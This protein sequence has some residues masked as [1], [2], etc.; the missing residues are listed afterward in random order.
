MAIKKTVTQ[1]TLILF[2]TITLLYL[3]NITLAQCFDWLCWESNEELF[4]QSELKFIKDM[5]NGNHAPQKES[6]ENDCPYHISSIAYWFAVIESWV[7]KWK[8]AQDT[9]NWYSVKKWS[10]KYRYNRK[11][12]Y[13]YLPASKYLIYENV[14]QSTLDFMYLIKYWYNCKL[15]RPNVYRYKMWAY[16]D[17]EN[18]ARYYRNLISSIENFEKKY[19][20]NWQKITDYQKASSDLYKSDIIENIF[21]W[22]TEILNTAS[23]LTNNSKIQIQK[24]VS[25][26][27]DTKN[28]DK[29]EKLHASANTPNN[30]PKQSEKSTNKNNKIQTSK[31]KINF[32][33][34]KN[35]TPI[36]NSS[37]N[38]SSNLLINQVNWINNPLNKFE[39]YSINK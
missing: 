38:I 19:F 20:W 24:I 35:Y 13:G 26:L 25:K 15:S 31:T 36:N 3:F 16:V 27:Q 28:I 7:W 10:G 37:I 33:S 30:N 14:M 17:D 23:K 5:Y 2:F 32:T 29:K 39:N 4:V 12:E 6:R 11:E 34:Y 21:T 1:K 18:S 9:N 22:S 8:M